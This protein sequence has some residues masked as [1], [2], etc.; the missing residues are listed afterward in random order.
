MFGARGLARVAKLA[1]LFAMT[2]VHHSITANGLTHH[3][4]DT[5]PEGAPRGV[6]LCLHGFPDDHHSWDALTPYLVAKGYRVIAPDLR[7]FGLTGMAERVSE[8]D[9]FDGA[10]PDVIAILDQL[11]IT[12]AHLVGHDFGSA[13]SWLLAAQYPDRFETLTAMAVG[14]QRAFLKARL[15]PVQMGKSRYILW[16]QFKGVCEWAYRRNDW[17]WFK[18]HWAG[19]YDVKAAIASLS[20]PGRLTAGLNWYRANI[21][22]SRMLFEP[23]V[24]TFGEERVR[25]PSLG[26]IGGEDRYLDTAQMDGSAAFIDA[27][28]RYEALTDLGHWL[29]CEAPE[30]VATVM[31]EFWGLE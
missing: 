19:H 22:L 25:I 21:G 15:T 30:R 14:H 4:C 7:G 5:R 20:R 11:G 16:H 18:H 28:W 27:P 23:P 6:V 29:H 1:K 12:R 3:V 13:L 9:M 2:S 10:M 26:L 17:A 24:G 8:Y 31:V